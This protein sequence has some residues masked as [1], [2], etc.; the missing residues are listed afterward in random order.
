MGLFK[1]NNGKL[2]IIKEDS[3]TLEKEMQTLCEKNMNKLFNLEFISSEFSVGNFRIDTLAY[4]K[5]TKSFVIIE[6]K[7]TRSYSVI[8]QGYSYLSNMLN[9]KAEYILQYITNTKKTINK[10]DIDW[11]QSR[12]FFVSP[13]YTKYQLESINFKDLPIYLYHIKKYK[14]NLIGLELITA[15][16]TSA[17]IN[18][19][20]SNEIKKQ[21]DK[22]VKVYTEK[23]HLENTDDNILE[24]YQEIKDAI[25]E[26]GDNIE[27]KATKNYIAFKINNTNI[28]DI[29]TQ[30]T[31]LKLFINLKKGELNDPKN[32][33]RD[34]SNIGAWGN[35][36]Y[37]IVIKNKDNIYD[38]LSLIKQSYDIKVQ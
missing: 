21:V 37:E 20:S 26:F 7:N 8:D 18:T 36:D 4:D 14:G 15:N 22:E 1:N 23:E 2:E 33:M 24:I 31:Q 38:I 32:L 27:I 34:I 16:D 17:S 5:H 6:Y 13:K 10:K 28:T 35:G 25:L 11:S 19:V 30:K 3:F 9:N 12:I 29:I